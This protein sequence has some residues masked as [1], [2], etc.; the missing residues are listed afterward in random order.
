MG[1]GTDAVVADAAASWGSRDRALE[2]DMTAVRDHFATVRGATSF[3]DYLR[4]GWQQ[5]VT[6]LAT[7]GKAPDVV[8]GSDSAWYE[9]LASGVAGI[10]G[11][12][13]AIIP[14]FIGG[15]GVGGTVG[16][17][18]AG[19][20]GTVAGATV[21]GFAGAGA[22]PASLRAA[23]MEAYTK[24]E[25]T[26]SADFIE[27]ALHVSWE[28]FKAGTVGAL[29]GGAGVATKAAL[30]PLVVSPLTKAGAITSAEIGTMATVGKAL[31][32]K[33]PEPQDFL[34]AAALIG[35]AKG[36]IATAGKLRT[37]YAA[38]GKTPLEV[39]ADSRGD[40][41]LLEFLQKTKPE[42]PNLPAI[43]K[44]L[45]LDENSRA[46]VPDYRSNEAAAL[47]ATAV[48]N[49]PF[50]ELPAVRGEPK[51]THV[52]YDFLNTSEE[53][54]S[55]LSR[56][57]SIYE[58]KI[59]AQR[60]GEVSWEA[61][62]SEAAKM[63]SDTLGGT[64]ST[65]LMPREPGTAAGAAEILARKQLTIGAAEDMAIRA[66][67]YLEKGAEASPEDT[68]AFL[69]SIERTALIQSEFLGARAEAGRALNILK[70]TAK[71][72]ERAKQIQKV[73]E[74][75]GK[76]PTTIAE[77]I[78]KLD[79]PAQALKFAKDA[80]KATSW[81]KIVEAWKAALLSGY[82]THTAN[83]LGNTAFL[84]LRAPIDAVAAGAGLL[85]G[86]SAA[87]RVGVAEPFARAAGAILGSWAAVKQLGTVLK[88]GEQPGKA[89]THR[90]AIEG[91]K[92]EVIR[93]PFRL[94]SAEDA[95]F[96]TLNERGELGALAS[97]Q[98]TI[99]GFNLLSAEYRTRVAQLY[100][101][102]PEK[103]A[104]EAKDAAERF[105]FNKELGEKGQALQS[106]VRTWHL[107]WLLP[108]I[109]TPANIIKELTRLTPLAP[110][111]KEWRDAIR[112]G[113]PNRDK[114][115]AEVAVGMSIM[116]TVFV[117][118]LNGEISGAGEPDQGKQR[119]NR[120][121]GWQP[122]SIKVGDTWYSYERLQPAGTLIGIA[123]D[124]A[125]VWDHTTEEEA[126][127]I[128]KM[129]SIAFA[130]AVTNQT[131]L[132]GV[133]KLAGVLDPNR[134]KGRFFEGF[135]G[136]MVPAIVSQT[137]NSMD[138]LAREVNSIVDAI[139]AR[140]PG[141]RETLLP[142]LDIFGEPEANKDRLGG[143]TPITKKTE[144]DDKVRTEA[145]RLGLS[146]SDA[147]KKAHVGRG[148]GKLGDVKLT[149]EQRNTFTDV[150]GHLA[151]EILDPIVNSPQWDILPPL[152]Q[153][154]AYAKAFLHAHRAGAAAALP[155]DLRAGIAAEITAK[156]VRELQPGTE[157]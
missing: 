135:A 76:D 78:G 150:S 41:V 97:R 81:E 131:F 5:S 61:T 154:R 37:I 114:A 127:K 18:V 118:A 17:A 52:N 152:V 85:R 133:T 96:K 12:V 30:G 157:E 148:S 125:E 109:R 104:A 110:L 11:D 151:H 103:M 40:P 121:A 46:A 39:V 86:A 149:P 71:D 66:K 117:K 44:P 83:M 80:V 138:P 43:Y 100:R 3:A 32:G 53:A 143:I 7:R 68:V 115:L 34:D 145:A 16:T 29:T 146:A 26:G 28:G 25:V 35:G 23:M 141:V 91:A 22:L 6:G 33:L 108:F 1:W 63:L 95:L 20:P 87:D 62:S 107:E 137:A 55:V 84:V 50:D 93:L 67:A 129:L 65:L 89:E 101:D 60:R 123:A 4:A 105:T 111:V 112:E 9:R 49:R 92:G 72:A 79:N 74:M 47:D 64:D 10:A 51:P 98:A 128:P 14:G 153:K 94:L 70:S 144:S 54:A 142:K 130:N 42:D 2:P 90:K 122:Y 88:T 82:V 69:A 124:L 126:D 24:G 113:G 58:E 57:S 48:M 102:P 140:I 45:A 120:A 73:V 134:P 13:P 77:M 116:T 36:T 15:A 155:P 31:E 156:V 106:F 139:K 119:V 59:Q 147:P 27:R 21:G 75:Y 99:E 56:L 8:A 19:P 136:S 38:T 132:Q